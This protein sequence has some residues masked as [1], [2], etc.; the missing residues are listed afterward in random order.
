MITPTEKM[1]IE[2]LAEGWQCKEIADH[3]KYSI[4]TIET[5]KYKLCRKLGVKN[6][7]HLVSYALR[8]G[9]IK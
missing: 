9:L 3:S 6:G 8:N 4:H 7:A 5:W 2:L 1:I